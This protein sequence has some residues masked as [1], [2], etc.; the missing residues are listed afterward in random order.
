MASHMSTES[1]AGG[2]AAFGMNF[3]SEREAIIG[4]I[5]KIQVAEACAGVALSSWAETC[6][7]PALRG[8]LRMIAEREA[9]H[10]RIFSQRIRD[11]GAECQAPLDRFSIESEA[12]IA[13]P[14]LTDLEKLTSLVERNGDPET[15]ISP[16]LAFAELLTEDLE[17]KEALK[18]YYADEISS[19]NWLRDMCRTLGGK[20]QSASDTIPHAA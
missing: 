20:Q 2:F 4:L 18:L 5:D 17:T 15:L 19:G 13:D 8:G 1:D 11:L 6:Q 10:G 12:C 14:N 16:V 7:I 9:F 3:A